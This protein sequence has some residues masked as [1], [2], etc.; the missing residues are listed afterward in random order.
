MRYDVRVRPHS[1]G[2][3][4]RFEHEQDEPLEKGAILNP[5]GMVYRVVSVLPGEAD[6]DAVIDAEWLAGP[7]QG[8]Y[9]P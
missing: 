1:G 7:A 2:Q 9:R 8:E 3:G 6:F 4:G 5:G